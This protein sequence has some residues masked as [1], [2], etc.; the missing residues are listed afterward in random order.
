MKVNNFGIALFALLAGRQYSSANTANGQTLGDRIQML[1]L[2]LRNIVANELGPRGYAQMA[3]AILPGE[4]GVYIRSV[5]KINDFL[6]RLIGTLGHTPGSHLDGNVVLNQVLSQWHEFVPL[7][8]TTALLGIII[9]YIQNSRDQSV[10]GVTKRS[11]RR[12]Q[13]D[14]EQLDSF[15]NANVGHPFFG[16]HWKRVNLALLGPYQFHFNFPLANVA[17]SQT[18]TLLHR[19]YERIAEVS[20]GLSNYVPNLD[21]LASGLNFTSLH[22]RYNNLHRIHLTIIK[23]TLLPALWHVYRTQRWEA[24]N[25]FLDMHGPSAGG[26][27]PYAQH[28]QLLRS[29][30]TFILTLATI[31]KDIHL[32]TALTRRLEWYFNVYKSGSLDQFKRPFL[33][34]LNAHGLGVHAKYLRAQWSIEYQPSGTDGSQC[35]NEYWGTHWLNILPNG[36]LVMPFYANT[37]QFPDYSVSKIGP[38]HETDSESDNP[39]PNQSSGPETPEGQSNPADESDQLGSNSSTSI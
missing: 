34:C 32:I 19:I 37:F 11:R 9:D 1:P 33:D 7:E 8:S 12:G 15:L 10:P 14:F 29:S 35:A 4:P 38:R 3:P 22:Q 18:L 17:D 26:Y 21:V 5:G 28:T 27:D 36:N 39:S 31:H 13:R 23:L 20:V 2:E 25:S 30:A 6:V 16:E 24:L